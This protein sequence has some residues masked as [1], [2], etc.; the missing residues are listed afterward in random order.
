M[1]SRFSK[2][3]TRKGGEASSKFD[4]VFSNKK[5]TLSTKWGETT[6][7]AQLGVKRPSFKPEVPELTKRPRFDDDDSSEDPFGFDSD[8]ESKTIT[9]RGTTQSEAGS[10]A[11]GSE[12]EQSRPQTAVAR[13]GTSTLVSGTNVSRGVVGH[14]STGKQALFDL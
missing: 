9:S 2:T 13:E 8:D 4:E 14:D 7:K 11:A 3:Y 1:T 6:Y 10:D 12:N 5:A